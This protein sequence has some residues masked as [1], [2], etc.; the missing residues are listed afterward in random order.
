MLATLIL[1]V[2]LLGFA[3]LNAHETSTVVLWWGEQYEFV[4][5]PLIV[6]LF[7]AF[8]LGLFVWFIVT[9]FKDIRMRQTV[10]EFRRQNAKLE[11]EI[12]ALRNMPVED[13]SGDTDEEL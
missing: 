1:F 12:K 8:A 2:V 9:V 13:I 11:A 7:V 10:S 3:I 5:V 6:V 4:D